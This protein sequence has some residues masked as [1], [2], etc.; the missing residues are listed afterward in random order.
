MSHMS[1]RS[2]EPHEPHVARIPN[3]HENPLPYYSSGHI[4]NLTTEV[5]IAEVQAVLDLENF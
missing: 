3:G 1:H 2:H 5:K 4:R